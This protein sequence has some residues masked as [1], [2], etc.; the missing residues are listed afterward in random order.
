M[1]QV[2][3]GD[4]QPE[5]GLGGGAVLDAPVLVVDP[6][7]LGL[8]EPDQA[9]RPGCAHAVEQVADLD[10][11][12]GGGADGGFGEEDGVG[13]EGADLGD[14]LA[15]DA[16]EG[17]GGAV[18]VAVDADPGDV[19]AAGPPG[20]DGAGVGAVGVDGPEPGDVVGALGAEQGDDVAP[21]G[22]EGGG[23]D[24]VVAPGVPGGVH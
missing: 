23:G 24:V 6:A 3:P 14:G 20:G 16:G 7:V 10:E 21:G 11:L 18:V 4:A 8:V 22:D 2:Q 12:A 17:V 19:G 1:D 13:G 9:Q 15:E 5:R